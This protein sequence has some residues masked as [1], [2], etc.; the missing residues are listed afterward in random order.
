MPYFDHLELPSA[1]DGDEVIWRYLSMDQLLNILNEETIHFSRVDHSSGSFPNIE[2]QVALNVLAGIPPEAARRS[3]YLMKGVQSAVFT[4]SWYESG[5]HE[6]L[7]WEIHGG[8]DKVAIRTTVDAL[9]NALSLSSQKI[10][11]SSVQ[12]IDFACVPMPTGNA[13]LPTLY[14]PQELRHDKEVLML[15]LQAGGKEVFTP[16]PEKGVG[17]KIDTTSLIKGVRVAA[18][19]SS[20]FRSLVLSIADRYGLNFETDESYARARPFCEFR[21][22]NGCSC[23]R[24]ARS[25]DSLLSH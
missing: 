12:Y 18:Q 17:V 19:S 25:V 3:L 5:A 6:H 2:S 15:L 4:N 11:M 9:Q 10:S 22:A 20:W 7:R 23:P 13:F 8:N 21:T 14:R 24:K 16:G 1:P